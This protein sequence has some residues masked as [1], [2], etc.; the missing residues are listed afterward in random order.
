M[1]RNDEHYRMGMDGTLAEKLRP[2]ER[3]GVVEVQGLWRYLPVVG[4][5]LLA[6]IFVASGLGKIGGWEATAGYMASKGLFLI[7]VLLGA[8]IAIEVL[9]GL[10][11]IL[12][13]KAR[14]GAGALALFL[15]PVTL[16]FHNFWA[17]SGSEAQTQMIMF[18]K[19]LSIIGGLVLIAAFGAGPLSLDHRRRRREPPTD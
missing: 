9:G 15:I 2:D 10:S 16:I 14:Y 11:V 7:P 17:M 5:A 12:G 1:T 18:M 8:T 6:V 13:Y 19:N 4:R 3:A